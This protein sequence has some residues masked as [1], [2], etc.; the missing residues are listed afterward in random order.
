MKRYTRKEREINKKESKIR[1][2]AI[3]SI[4]S[5]HFCIKAGILVYYSKYMPIPPDEKQRKHWKEYMLGALVES[6]SEMTEK[7]LMS[8]VF[9][10][11]EKWWGV[12]LFWS[13]LSLS[14]SFFPN[15][16][17]EDSLGHLGCSQ[18][19][20]MGAWRQSRSKCWII[21]MEEVVV[22]INRGWGGV[23]KSRRAR[24]RVQLKSGGG[25]I[26]IASLGYFGQSKLGFG[27][28]RGSLFISII[29]NVYIS[30]SI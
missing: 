26:V 18:A 7:L 12:V 4:P 6:Y 27:L 15:F 30:W 22:G 25:G 11:I 8:K 3:S 20:L 29:K 23:W 28:T 9:I 5:L 10:A 1:E 17:G 2:S 13:V 24:S 21:L 14:F 19:I 16:Y